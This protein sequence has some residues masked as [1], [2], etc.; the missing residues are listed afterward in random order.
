[1]VPVK[2]NAD[3]GNLVKMFF[4]NYFKNVTAFNVFA[5]KAQGPEFPE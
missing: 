5:L 1:M 4:K 2:N 3:L